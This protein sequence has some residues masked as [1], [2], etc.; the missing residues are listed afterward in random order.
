MKTKILNAL[1]TEYV[2]LGLGDKAFDG[3]AAFLEKTITK[4]EDIDGVI[5]SEDTKNLLKAFHGESD[6]LRNR[7][8]QLEREFN[9]YKEAHPEGGGGGGGTDDPEIAKLKN[10]LETLK[11]NYAD[12]IKQGKYNSLREAVRGKAAELKVSNVP[13]WNDVVSGASI[14]DNTTEET[15]LESVKPAYEA[16]L[17]AYIGD[18]TAPYR[19]DGTPKP[20]EISAADRAARAKEDAQR[21][22]ESQ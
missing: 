22:R 18:G 13:I 9:A 14:D 10:E 15:L 8:A 16:K 6:S 11:T 21:V 2:K 17:K 19:G 3:V 4:E 20:A 5:K 12:Q 7:N 1:K